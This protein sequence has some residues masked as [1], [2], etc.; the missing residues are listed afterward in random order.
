MINLSGTTFRSGLIY[1][2]SCEYLGQPA[3]VYGQIEYDYNDSWRNMSYVGGNSGTMAQRNNIVYIGPHLYV[4]HL[5]PPVHHKLPDRQ[6]LLG[7]LWVY[8]WDSEQLMK[9]CAVCSRAVCSVLDGDLEMI[10]YIH[11]AQMV[12]GFCERLNKGLS[13]F[14]P[15]DTKQL[16]GS[17]WNRK[18]AVTPAT[19]LESTAAINPGVSSEA[20]SP[21]TKHLEES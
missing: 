2:W 5:H 13:K 20:D 21:G 6:K 15:R 8:R 14:L 18:N 1:I 10:R 7:A 4:A 3:G 12:R 16:I 19:N 11:N 17:E 9:L